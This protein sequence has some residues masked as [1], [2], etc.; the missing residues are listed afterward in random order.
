MCRLFFIILTQN[1][2]WRDIRLGL[3]F[4]YLEVVGRTTYIDVVISYPSCP[5]HITNN[6]SDT[7]TDAANLDNEQFKTNHY[8]NWNV[9]VIP[10]AF[11]ATGRLGPSALKYISCIT[12][13]LGKGKAFYIQEIQCVIAKLNGQMFSK[14]IRSLRISGSGVQEY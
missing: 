9:P 3:I 12:K 8:R 4:R 2:T 6:H 7:I 5:T 13:H 1:Q 14:F 11:E 10:F